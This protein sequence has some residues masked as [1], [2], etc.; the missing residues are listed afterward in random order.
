MKSIAAW[1]SEFTNLQ[2]QSGSEINF[3]NVKNAVIL[4]LNKTD[5]KLG[6]E[7]YSLLVEPNRIKIEAREPAGIFY[8]LQS[9]RQQLPEQIEATDKKQMD[10]K[11]PA[12]KILDNPCFS[13]RGLMLDCI[14]TF[15]PVEYIKKYIDLLALYK[16][17]VLHYSQLDKLGVLY[18]KEGD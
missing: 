8:G 7:G 11:I 10:W 6:A 2:I 9:I 16:L 5:K 18:G 3:D 1:F 13:W 12:V 17:N 4:V 14:R 15:L